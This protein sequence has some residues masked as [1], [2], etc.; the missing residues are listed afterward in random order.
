MA[1]STVGCRPAHCHAGEHH[2]LNQVHHVDVGVHNHQIHAPLHDQLLAPEHTAEHH[3]E[4]HNNQG[5]PLC[6]TMYRENTTVIHK[7]KVVT[8][9]CCTVGPKHRPCLVVTISH[10]C[11]CVCH[12]GGAAQT[13]ATIIAKNPLQCTKKNTLGGTQFY[14]L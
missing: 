10:I 3:L 1:S 2:Q 4:L 11:Q 14:K 12:S 7:C 6:L 8:I 9:L 5:A 13:P